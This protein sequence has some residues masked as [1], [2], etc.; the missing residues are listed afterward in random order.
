M[1]IMR[2]ISFAILL[3]LLSCSSEQQSAVEYMNELSSQVV[4]CTTEA[5]FDKVFE[6]IIALKDD[7]RF[8]ENDGVSNNDKLEIVKGLATLINEALAVK[9]ILYVMPASVNPTSQDMRSLV[10]KCINDSVNVY[11]SPYGDVRSI[12]YNY[13]KISE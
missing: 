1:Y 11:S 10:E 13:Y 12:V 2:K 7:A 6:K 9:A 3:L 4:S 5:E 8:K